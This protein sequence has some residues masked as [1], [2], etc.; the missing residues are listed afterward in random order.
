MMQAIPSDYVPE[1]E[2]LK[3]FPDGKYKA[4]G[5]TWFTLDERQNP[6][7]VAQ[8]DGRM[9]G[10]C[11]FKVVGQ[12]DGAPM[13]LELSE[14]SLL[15]KAFGGDLT[16]LPEIPTLDKP[17]KV[18]A[19]M[20]A[21]EKAIEASDKEVS[22]EVSG[23]WVSNNSIP[24]MDV[25]GFIY[26]VYEDTLPAK[27]GKIESTDGQYGRYFITRWKVLGGEGGG[28]SP[29]TGAN[30]NELINYAVTVENG[31][32]DWARTPGGGYTSAAVVQCKIMSLTAPEMFE[33][34]YSAIDP[35]NL[36]LEWSAKAEKRKQVLKGNRSKSEKGKVRMEWSTVEPVFNFVA[37][38]TEPRSTPSAT[39][40]SIP[41]GE[42]DAKARSILKRLV[43]TL[44]G[45]ECFNADTFDVNT[46]GK[47]TAKKY[48][49]P[50]KDAGVISHGFIK[51]MKWDEVNAILDNIQVPDEHKEFLTNLR[52]E[53]AAVG[54]GADD[55]SDF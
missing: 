34:G 9:V 24:G 11:R 32:P 52:H 22:I 40:S 13:S 10:R 20:T 4:T 2:E 41:P 17:G 46:V 29:F 30:F 31:K 7:V 26:F 50:L 3:P 51:S 1:K 42:D 16:S 21:V 53:L 38:R 37:N 36:L 15:V 23:G 43:N 14:M 27:S 33:D 25:I 28:P 35:Y 48:L 54:I 19:Y 44:G 55:A 47:R 45:E 8:K 6:V 39:V 12:E 18:S 49:G 5:I